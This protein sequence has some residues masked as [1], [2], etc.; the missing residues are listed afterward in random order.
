M[1]RT[2]GPA[3]RRN[4]VS[5]AI[6]ASTM[7]SGRLSSGWPSPR[8]EPGVY[9]P[10]PRSSNTS[11]LVLS[12]AKPRSNASRPAASRSASERTA[13]AA[14]TLPSKK[15]AQRERITPQRDQ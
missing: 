8:A 15:E 1:R 9:W 3:P 2:P 4:A 11:T 6:K 10:P 7:G 14:I 13:G 5:C 12:A